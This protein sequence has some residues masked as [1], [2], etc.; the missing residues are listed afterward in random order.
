ML[1]MNTKKKS[2]ITTA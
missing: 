1:I 2:G